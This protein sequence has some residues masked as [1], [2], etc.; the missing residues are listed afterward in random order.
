MITFEKAEEIARNRISADCALIKDA[1]LE[2]PYGWYFP[3]QSKEFL[4]TGDIK[5]MLVGSGGFIVEK[6]SGSVVEFGSA[7]STEKNFKIYERGLCGRSDL[8]I[9]KVKELNETIRLLNS[10]SMTYIATEISNG[11]EWKLPKTYKQK[12]IK[13]AISK[14]P[15]I[16]KNQNFYFR[17]DVFEKIDNS[18]CFEYELIKHNKI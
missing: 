4:E 2:K 9:L 8:I 16:F 15:C 5:K 1:I 3:F 10:L 11:I 17:Y 13:E 18:K 6:D 7:Y 14:L 12:Q